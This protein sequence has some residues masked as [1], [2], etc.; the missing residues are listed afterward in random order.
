MLG[1]SDSNKESGFLA[2]AWM[3]HQA[4]AA[5]VEAARAH[6]VE[7]TLFHGRGGAIG[8]GG[9]PANRA[10]VGGA[11]GSVDG[12][13]KLTEQGEVIAANYGDPAIARRHLEQL[14][15]AVLIASTPEHDSAAAAAR[16]GRRPAPERAVRDRSVR[17]PRAG[18]RGSRV[19]RFLPVDHAD[20]RAVRPSPGIPS[21]RPRSGGRRARRGATHR[22]AACHPVDL[23]L[24]AVAD[25]P[26]RL[27]RPRVGARRV[28]RSARRGG[29]P[30]DRTAVPLMAVPGVRHRQRGDDP[31]QGGYGHRPT[32]CVARPG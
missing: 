19:R 26:A 10:I 5:L 15:G 31:G 25:Q 14:T 2:A 16:K 27:V 28:R 18:P 6:G 9:G 30:R 17:V 7:L 4:Q 13:L 32:L 20:R 29:H 11:P 8:R 3:L 22:C 12:R 24:V 1:Y 23:R 21:R